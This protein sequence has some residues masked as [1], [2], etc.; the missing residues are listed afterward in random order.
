MDTLR[1]NVSVRAV[2]V[3]GDKLLIV[4]GDGAS[5]FWCLPGGRMEYGETLTGAL[6]RE[7][8]EETGLDVVTQ[9]AFA[10]SEF[11]YES[12]TFHNVDI[13]FRTQIIGNGNIDPLQKWPHKGDSQGELLVIH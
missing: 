13:F 2:I 3:C 4:N 5:G 1:P 9:D 8:K 11:L 12:N 10:V 6:A 7:V